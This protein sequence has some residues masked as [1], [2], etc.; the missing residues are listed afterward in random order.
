MVD[1]LK[2]ML[3][4][5]DLG[6]LLPDLSTVFG[7]IEGA[8]RLLILAGP[9]IMLVMGLIYF[10]LS[11]KEANYSLG[12]RTWFGMGSRE[13][14]RF[15]QKLAGLVWGGLGLILTVIMLL[16]G[17]SLRKMEPE[18]M[19]WAGVR[20]LLWEAGLALAAMLGINLTAMVRFNWNGQRRKPDQVSEEDTQS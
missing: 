7:K 5:I 6:A 19:V 15:T 1:T 14:W 12:Y 20:C 10:C 13:A 17:T 16:I 18:A 2:K 4:E 3:E 9:V 8:V 11:P